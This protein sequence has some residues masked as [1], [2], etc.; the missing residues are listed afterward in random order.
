MC[1]KEN[2]FNQVLYKLEENDFKVRNR[3]K[4]F[5]EQ[6]LVDTVEK[7]RI[8]IFVLT[9]SYLKSDEFFKLHFTAHN[10]KKT[11]IYL[12]AED[13]D[14]KLAHEKYIN[15]NQLNVIKFDNHVDHEDFINNIESFH[16]LFY[17][18]YSIIGRQDLVRFTQN[19]IKLESFKSHEMKNNDDEFVENRFRLPIHCLEIKKNLKEKSKEIGCI[20]YF[21]ERNEVIITINERLLIYDP[22]TFKFLRQISL[23]STSETEVR[24]IFYHEVKNKL[25]LLG[26]CKLYYLN[27]DT[28]EYTIETVDNFDNINSDY[29]NSSCLTSIA[30]NNN[31]IY[32]YNLVMNDI[33]QIDERGRIYNVKIKEPD[34]PVKSMK[35]TNDFLFVLKPDC[36]LVY[37]LDAFYITSF[38]TSIIFR[39]QCFFID[40][41]TPNY[42]YILD[43]HDKYLKVF[44]LSFKYIG[45]IKIESGLDWDYTC[46]G[47]IINGHL[48]LFDPKS[49]FIQE[50]VYSSL[51]GDQNSLKYDANGF[52]VCK[53]NRYN[54]HMCRNPYQLPCGNIACLECI[55]DKY[56][57]FFNKFRCDFDDC[58]I[59]HEL[60]NRLE[61]ISITDDNLKSI[62]LYQT[63]YAANFPLFSDYLADKMESFENWFNFMDEDLDIRYESLN[64]QFDELEVNVLDIV[65]K[66]EE[67]LLSKI[68]KS[69]ES[70]AKRPKIS[71]TVLKDINTIK[72]FPF[73]SIN[74]MKKLDVGV[75]RDENKDLKNS[76]DE[77][78]ELSVNSD[79]DS[80]DW[81]S[82]MTDSDNYFDDYHHHHQF[83]GFHDYHDFDGENDDDDSDN[84]PMDTCTIQ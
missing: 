26:D 9:N 22:N 38:G 59:E 82:Y 35:F 29:L 63:E 18:I 4:I 28:A 8:I 43:A 68:Y 40:D 46:N 2:N 24:G 57:L 54:Q 27:V 12:L 41:K 20:F 67:R 5:D 47:N 19:S 49:M 52:Y 48:V 3:M 62:C 37:D 7:S 58:C 1:N 55:Y 17:L 56:N 13:I 83:H 39:A 45:R 72:N 34:V 61:R 70:Q 16:R 81:G 32:L 44:N 66:T 50:I 30:Y 71:K 80:D 65:D 84:D 15:L 14:T 42:L 73:K 78:I 74:S 60:N 11:I 31:K 51:N 25:C 76:M 77:D 23:R 33:I 36:V 21:K 69:Q 79:T 64:I 75:L 10:D 53:L 6:E